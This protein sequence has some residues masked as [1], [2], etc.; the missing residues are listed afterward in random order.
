MLAFITGKTLL[1]EEPLYI[2]VAG[3]MGT[4]NGD[5]MIQGISMYLEKV[6]QAGGIAGKKV[7][8]LQFDD[9]NQKKKAEEQA[10]NIVNSQA[11]AVI[12]HYGSSP[13]IAAASIY[14]KHGIAAITGTATANEIT[15]NNEWFFRVIFTN[16]DQSAVI[17][18]YAR[19]ILGYKK[20]YILFD[21]DDYGKTLASAFAQTAKR[22]GLEIEGQW[23]F[24]LEDDE[25][26][27]N[28]FGEMVEYLDSIEDEYGILFL[29]THSTEALKTITGLRRLERKVPIIGADALASSYF[30]RTF[31]EKYPQ[32]KQFPG[33]FTD[34]IHLASPFLIEIA[35]QSAQNFQSDFDNKKYPKES[36]TTSAMYYDATMVALQAV[37]KTLEE[38]GENGSLTEKRERVKDNLWHLSKIAN[39]VEGV[40]GD[41]YFDKNGDAIKSVPIAVFKKGK[42]IVTMEQY[43]PLTNLQNIDNLLQEVLDN[44]IIQVNDKFMRKANVVYVGVDFNDI[45]E[46]NTANSTYTAD[47][48]IWFRYKDNKNEETKDFDRVNFVN[49]FDPDDDLDHEKHFFKEGKSSLDP[50]IVT[51]T[52]R[53][54]TQFKGT[55]DFHDYPLDKQV[56]PLKF[57]HNKLTKDQLIYVVDLRGMKRT[58]TDTD[59]DTVLAKNIFSISG[60]KMNTVWFF[61]SSQKNDSTLGMPDLFDS[62]Q[63]IE[64]SQFNVT[65]NI[66][67]HVLTFVIKNLLPTIFIILLG[68]VV[69]FTPSFG[70]RMSLNI[71]MILATSLFHLQLSSSLSAIEYTVLI[72]Y[73]FYMV[74]L[75]AVVG[76]VLSLFIYTREEELTAAQGSLEKLKEAKEKKKKAKR[77]EDMDIGEIE[78]SG[79]GQYF[80]DGVKGAESDDEKS[81]R[82]EAIIN[83]EQ[84]LIKRIVRVGRYGYPLVA[85]LTLIVISHSQWLPYFMVFSQITY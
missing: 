61:Q 74:Y 32:E 42:P 3:P 65:I 85:V 35:G 30:M 37:R 60:W 63:R 12:G 79:E 47:F 14:K 17:A 46:L 77:R 33:Y 81:E 18:N 45:S 9:Q 69:Y 57:Q 51:K 78:D 73:V 80:G 67:R 50:G 71:N 68:Y 52:Y 84:L 26:F 48:Y 8:L 53:I 36:I 27:D 76:I 43:Q 22:I 58:D 1:W 7:K 5:A 39:A 59:T 44:E 16:R 2:A 28:N 64:Y 72:E 40:T 82:L 24:N 10:L 4:S 21:E 29:A 41:L 38:D 31:K 20:A 15:E 23:S 54:K 25:S 83:K 34:G 11:L 56:L 19:K 6:N 70:L 55:F 62:E 13:S 49:I 75:L 66:A